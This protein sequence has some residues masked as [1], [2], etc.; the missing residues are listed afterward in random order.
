MFSACWWWSRR[1]YHVTPPKP[2]FRRRNM[3]I[4]DN[5]IIRSETPLYEAGW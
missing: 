4:A 3:N 1:T 5:V 2:R